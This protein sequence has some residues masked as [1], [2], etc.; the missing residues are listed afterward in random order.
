MKK[1]LSL[2]IFCTVTLSFSQTKIKTVHVK[3]AK[4]PITIDAVLNEPSW[5]QTEPATNF[6]QHFPTDTEQA[7]QQA[8]IK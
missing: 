5:S 6:W 8:E 3:Y 4:E 7:K 2:T 1:L